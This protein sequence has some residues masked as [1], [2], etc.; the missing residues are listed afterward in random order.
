MADV[1]VDGK[2][3]ASFPD[4]LC[5]CP[6]DATWN[7]DLAAIFFAGVK[8]GRATEN[9]SEFEITDISEY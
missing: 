3:I 7:R 4:N 1:I 9:D 2:V 6:E 8:A 5:E